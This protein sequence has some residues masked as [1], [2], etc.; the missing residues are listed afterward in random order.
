MKQWLEPGATINPDTP[1]PH[2]IDPDGTVVVTDGHHT[3]TRYPA[4]VLETHARANPDALTWHGRRLA[5]TW[6]ATQAGAA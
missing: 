1:Y 4:T 2:R 3:A 5:A 6:R